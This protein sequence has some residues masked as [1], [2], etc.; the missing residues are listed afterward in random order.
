[1]IPTENLKNNAAS[2]FSENTGPTTSRPEIAEAS[3]GLIVNQ[4]ASKILPEQDSNCKSQGEKQAAIAVSKPTFSLANDFGRLDARSVDLERFSWWIL[5]CVVGVVSLAGWL[6]TGLVFRGAF[7]LPQW[8]VL[9]AILTFLTAM[10][11]ASRFF[12]VKVF[13]T[14]Y[15]QITQDGLEIRRGIWWRHRIFIP[16]NRIQ[17][18]DVRQGPI[19][20]RF[21]LATL[22]VNTGGTHNPSISLSGLSLSKAEDLRV[23][24]SYGENKS[25]TN[26]AT[27][28]EPIQ[29]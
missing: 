5:V 16:S 3:D 21:E 27:T 12:P 17:H 20:R 22:V 15:W 1:M 25:R 28:S 14:T 8:F 19:E 7:D 9:V 18:T 2:S 26:P 6:L 29:Q 24:L 11:W 13:E 23:E 4:I 10:I